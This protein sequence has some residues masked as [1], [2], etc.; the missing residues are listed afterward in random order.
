MSWWQLNLQ[1]VFHHIIKIVLKKTEFLPLACAC[2]IIEHASVLTGPKG[3]LVTKIT[4]LL[5]STCDGSIALS[6]E[7]S[8]LVCSNPTFRKSCAHHSIPDALSHRCFVYRVQKMCASWFR[9]CP[10]CPFGTRPV[11]TGR[12][13]RGS[14]SHNFWAPSNFI[15]PRKICLKHIIKTK[16]FP[17]P[18]MHLAS[19]FKTWLRAWLEISW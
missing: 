1:E 7:A 4:V 14:A 8:N 17:P 18:R 5:S 6:D 3:Q 15:V 11:A 2:H 19:N 16:N 12:A 13:F 9:V 10:P